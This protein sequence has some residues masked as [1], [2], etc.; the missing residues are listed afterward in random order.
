MSSPRIREP[1]SLSEQVKQ[2]IKIY[3]PRPEL[4]R[5]DNSVGNLV[6]KMLHGKDNFNADIRAEQDDVS[7][8]NIFAHLVSESRDFGDG[9]TGLVVFETNLA[10]PTD[11]RK[12]ISVVLFGHN[13]E[14]VADC[15]PIID[16]NIYDNI[17]TM[18]IAPSFDSQAYYFQ[19]FYS[20]DNLRSNP[21][22]TGNTLHIRTP[23]PFTSMQFRYYGYGKKYEKDSYNNTTSIS[24]IDFQYP[25]LVALEVASYE[26]KSAGYQ[27]EAANLDAVKGDALHAFLTDQAGQMRGASHG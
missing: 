8:N 24:W 5:M 10:L 27:Q 26:L 25:E 4:R 14:K 18:Q 1:F 16:L 6:L 19:E 11:F 13:G 9:T 7:D 3:A 23:V 17:D 12:E 22:W 2:Y 20:D 15:V 21:Y